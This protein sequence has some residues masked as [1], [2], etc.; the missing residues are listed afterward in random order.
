MDKNEYNRLSAENQKW[1]DDLLSDP[2]YQSVSANDLAAQYTNPEEETESPM[3]PEEFLSQPEAELEAETK[4]E[5][6]AELDLEELKQFTDNVD[7]EQASEIDDAELEKLLSEDWLTVTEQ[8]ESPVEIIE[9]ETS[10]ADIPAQEPQQTPRRFRPV[11]EKKARPKKKDE[12]GLAG[13]PNIIS[14]AI[15]LVLILAIGI[16]LGHLFWVCCADVMAFGKPPQKV[17]ITITEDDT[18]DTI[19]Q[20]L[21]NANLVRYP[22]LFKFFATVTGKDEDICV[23]TFTLNSQLDYNAM[24]N[25]MYTYGESR[26]V[27]DIMFPEGYNCAQIFKLLETKNV[28]SAAELEEYAAN[29]ELGDY[30]FLEGVPR[31]NKYCLEGYM[32]PDT[33]SF[34]T[35]DNPRRVI[36]K[37]LDEFGSRFTDKMKEDFETM[38]KQ[39]AARL[40]SN[41]FGAAYIEE[42]KLTLHQVVT[43]ASIV[44]KETSS[45]SEC[46]DIS[47]VFYNRLVNPSILSLGADATVY[48]AIGDYLGEID[49]LTSAH[50]NVDSPYNTRKNQGIPPGP[51]CNMGVQALYATLEPNETRYHYFVY[52]SKAGAHR[53]AVT[54]SEHFN[55]VNE[56]AG[57]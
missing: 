34:Y 54:Q 52:D 48:Y 49:E 37:F 36:E 1:L 51:I 53:F 30:W 3:S 9:E 45:D 44:Q 38:Q 25:A 32:A 31:G 17:T 55:N 22:G 14:T 23:G 10:L 33:Y 20:K 4:L 18:I 41:G 26:E 29:G 8:E 42:H 57:G 39:Y 19:S 28:C 7:E 6:E 2:D 56:L 21:G 11:I 5:A 47:S 43:L 13:I 12:Y 16:S 40:R 35:N 46:Y 15:W 24:I 50:L 27:V